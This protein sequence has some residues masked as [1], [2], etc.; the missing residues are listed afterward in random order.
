[1]AAEPDPIFD[2][3]EARP[4]AWTDLEKAATAAS[5]L[6]ATFPKEQRQSNIVAGESKIVSTD[7][8]RWISA[9]CASRNIRSLCPNLLD[10]R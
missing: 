5:K 3:I 2:A 6:Q 7:D 10:T 8:A 1:M 4:Q 9:E